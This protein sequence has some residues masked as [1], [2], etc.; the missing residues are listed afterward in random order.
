M[1]AQDVCSQVIPPRHIFLQD[2]DEK[3]AI[4]FSLLMLAACS[5]A[6]RDQLGLQAVVIAMI[7]VQRITFALMAQSGYK[8]RLKDW[9]SRHSVHK[10]H[11]KV[12]LTRTTNA[13]PILHTGAQSSG[14]RSPLPAK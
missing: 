10:R 8:H 4:L 1:H 5:A 11:V 7:H 13:S 9:A 14:V 12:A 3:N 2:L 6:H